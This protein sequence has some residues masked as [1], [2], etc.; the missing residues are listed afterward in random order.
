MTDTVDPNTPSGE[1]PSVL[2]QVEAG[3]MGAIHNAEAAVQHLL[4]PDTSA[5]ETT[6]PAAPADDTPAS[7]L[8]EIE[9]HAVFWGGDVG[10][11]IRSAVGRLRAALNL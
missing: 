7:I 1:N 4:H 6:T 2:A 5:P 3:V 10:A 8:Q 11:K 9:D